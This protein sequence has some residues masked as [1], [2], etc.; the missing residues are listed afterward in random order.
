MR[1]TSKKSSKTRSCTVKPCDNNHGLEN[2]GGSY[3]KWKVV[4]KPSNVP[5]IPGNVRPKDGYMIEFDNTDGG[6]KEYEVHQ[7]SGTLWG[8]A[9]SGLTYTLCAW[10]YNMDSDPRNGIFHSRLWRDNGRVYGSTG[11]G[12][13]PKSENRKWVYKCGATYRVNAGGF[14]MKQFSW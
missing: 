12:P 14:K 7:A 5:E 9:H 4:P 6:Y 13:L 1:P 10:Q 8:M 11:L 3:G 2:Q